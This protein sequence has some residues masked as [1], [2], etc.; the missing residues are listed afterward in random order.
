MKKTISILS[1]TLV[2]C[3]FLFQSC[4]KDNAKTTGCFPNDSTYRH[5]V[6]KPATVRQQ[7]GGSFY[8]VEK[9][10]VDTRLNPCNLPT[11]FQADNLQVTISGEVKVTIQGGPGPCCT[12]NFVITKISR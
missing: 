1:L 3:S 7:P 6:D 11:G 10:T 4:Q 5:I 8:L 2:L 9:G 12:E